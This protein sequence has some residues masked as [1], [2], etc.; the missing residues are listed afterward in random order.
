MTMRRVLLLASLAS[1]LALP[2][3]SARVGVTW[4]STDGW[5]ESCFEVSTRHIGDGGSCW[6]SDTHSTPEEGGHDAQETIG[7]YLLVIA[8]CVSIG[9]GL[10]HVTHECDPGAALCAE[11]LETQL[12][13]E[14]DVDAAE[15]NPVHW[16]CEILDG[17]RAA[18]P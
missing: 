8:V 7:V 6:Y 1:L 4:G 13:V 14:E 2:T 9:N 15:G 10:P 17:S 16:I 12:N 18:E 3:A 11:T 5:S